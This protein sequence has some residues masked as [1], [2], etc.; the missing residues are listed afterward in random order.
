MPSRREVGST[1]TNR[2]LSR[3]RRAADVAIVLLLTPP[4]VLLLALLL[5]ALRLSLGV[6]PWYRQLRCGAG[7][8][9]F[10]LYKLRTIPPAA[11]GS[12]FSWSGLHDPRATRLGNLLRI[13]HW[14]EVPQFWNVLW[15]DM[16]LVGPRPERPGI[17]AH[18]VPVVPGYL[19]R[20]L[21]VPGVTGWAAVMAPYLD[22]V[23]DAAAKIALD[24]Q[25]LAD[26]TL[27]RDLRVVAIT[28]SRML[29][30]ARL[31]SLARRLFWPARRCSRRPV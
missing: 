29:P 5:P 25:Y 11:A 21:P 2:P 12:G 4:V 15:G 13:L 8:R 22:P 30:L 19:A 10:V 9:V 18:L 31:G 7:G 6:S 1:T 23:R 20:T 27:A 16:T 3:L 17:V 26:P 28:C 24:L 14:D